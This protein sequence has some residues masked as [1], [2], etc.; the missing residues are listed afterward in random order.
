[1]ICVIADDLSGAAELAGV[2]LRYGLS[3]EIHLTFDPNSGADLVCVDTDSRSG[4]ADAAAQRV[5]QVV[6]H[7]RAA[8]I[9]QVFKKVDSVLRGHVAVELS[10]LM[11][12][13]GLKRVLLVPANPDLGR[14]ISAGQY[15][16]HGVPLHKTDFAHDPEHPLTSSSV[17]EILASHTRQAVRMVQ[18]G[19]DL[20]RCGL[21][22]GEATSSSDITGWA[23]RLEGDTVPAGAAEFFA[24]YLEALG[25]RRAAT[26]DAGLPQEPKG[27]TLFVCGSTSA[28]SRSFCSRWERRGRP[29]LRMPIDLLQDTGLESALLSGWA[30]AIVDALEQHGRAVVTI[31]LPL[32]RDPGISQR[33]SQ[34]LGVVV[35]LTLERAAVG[36]VNVEG[37][38]TAGALVNELSWRQMRA[39]KELGPGAVCMH[40]RDGIGPRLTMK[41]GSYPW[42]TEITE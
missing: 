39:L 1:M 32:R 37:G 22:V 6:A 2:G 17:P 40:S 8:G 14:V 28:S 19:G 25:V 10:A 15:L 12:G 38:A 24:A 20:A 34:Y 42:P 3:S 36:R 35:R 26:T 30:D 9:N 11:D 7:C 21:L 27:P 13:L 16:I 31:D 29:I 4:T 23:S 33:L 18:H 41:P 5:S